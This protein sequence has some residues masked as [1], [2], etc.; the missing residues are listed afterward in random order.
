MEEKAVGE[1]ISRLKSQVDDTVVPKEIEE[2]IN[3]LYLMK[4]AD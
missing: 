2:L 1:A 4:H 3:G